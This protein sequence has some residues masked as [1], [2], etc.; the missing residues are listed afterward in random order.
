MLRNIIHQ[1][2]SPTKL[3]T[4]VISETRRSATFFTTNPTWTGMRSGTGLSGE[5]TETGCPNHGKAVRKS[6]TYVSLHWNMSGGGNAEINCLAAITQLQQ[7]TPSFCV[8]SDCRA[9]LCVC[10]CQHSN[11]TSNI[12]QFIF[13]NLEENV[14]DLRHLSRR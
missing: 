13:R 4:N 5:R 1:R 9:Y 14:V 10:S 12:L 3:K 7:A 11:Q 8:F 2:Q 6:Q